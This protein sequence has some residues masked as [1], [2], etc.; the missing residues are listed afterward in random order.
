M[1]RKIRKLVKNPDLFFRDYFLKRQPLALEVDIN[2]IT[3]K[4]IAAK[5]T[6]LNR[7]QASARKPAH[8]IV[9]TITSG[10]ITFSHSVDAVI[11][12]VDGNDPEF[13]KSRASYSDFDDSGKVSA[14]ND[15]RYQN[16]DELRYCVRSI[17][18]YAPWIRKVYIVT[19]G[20]IP[21]WYDPNQDRVIIVRHDEI[22]DKKYLPT[23][24]S[25]VIE[26]CLHNIPEL[27]ERYIYFNDDVMLLRTA[28]PN[29]FFTESGLM[30]GFISSATIPNGPAHAGDTPS[31][32]GIKNARRL[33]FSD[34][35]YYFDSKFAHTYHPQR[36]SV[37]AACEEKFSDELH[38]CR[39]N[40]FRNTT[41][42]LCTSFLFP[43]FAYASGAGVFSKV[44]A[45]YFNIRDVSAINLYTSLLNFRGKVGGPASVCLND[46]LPDDQKYNFEEYEN[47]LCNFLKT[48][49]PV[50]FSFE[51]VDDEVQEINVQQKLVAVGE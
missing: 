1:G 16:R 46:H 30:R 39:L 42:I 29:D 24:N 13:Q 45:W 3:T 32:V 5:K 15:A 17:L 37:A 7:V 21:H 26:S 40:K 50:K 34:N 51:L 36:K 10:V 22:I 9:Q 11:T 6:K 25:H 43:C 28:R 47:S 19:N 41:D 44:R 20:Q 33:L 48:Y 14:N 27:S 38:M 4:D 2:R 23:F 12:W 49:Y 35:G 18:T 31:M 8:S